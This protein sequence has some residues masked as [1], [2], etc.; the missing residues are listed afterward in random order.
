MHFYCF[1]ARYWHGLYV[2]YKDV[3][4]DVAKDCKDRPIR[5]AIYVTCAYCF[6]GVYRLHQF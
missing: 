6:F 1:A 5:A 3:A 4:F 2:D